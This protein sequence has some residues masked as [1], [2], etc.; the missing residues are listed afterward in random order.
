M[1]WRILYVPCPAVVADGV[2]LAVRGGVLA[3]GRVQFGQV[4]GVVVL[5]GSVLRPLWGR[6]PDVLIVELHGVELVLAEL[7]P[8]L[9]L[10]L[11]LLLVVGLAGTGRS[12]GGNVVAGGSLDTRRSGRL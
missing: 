1:S 12:Q 4:V 2:F 6:P 5:A 9:L 10:L 7:I 11:L 8:G 3:K